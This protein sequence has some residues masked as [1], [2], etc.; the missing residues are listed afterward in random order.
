MRPQHPK[1]S[2]PYAV[3]VAVRSLM[4]ATFLDCLKLLRRCGVAHSIARQIYDTDADAVFHFASAE[5]VQIRTPLRVLFEVIGH[6][7]RE[8]NMTGIATIH[9]T[10]RDVDAS[11]RYIRLF[12]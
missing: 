6:M 3:T 8:Q 4:S 12:V 1:L 9:H 10:L 11:A 7:F 5:I 2:L